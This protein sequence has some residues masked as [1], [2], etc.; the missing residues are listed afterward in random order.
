MPIRSNRYFEEFLKTNPNAGN[1]VPVTDEDPASM[2]FLARDIMEWRSLSLVGGYPGT[3]SYEPNN[4]LLL[5]SIGHL[6]FF[7]GVIKNWDS[8]NY[9]N[10]ILLCRGKEGIVYTISTTS[11]LYNYKDSQKGKEEYRKGALDTRKTFQDIV[12]YLSYSKDRTVQEMQ[13]IHNYHKQP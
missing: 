9:W 1:Y 12:P 10:D 5:I 8:Y 3:F 2:R 4:R 6:K 13:K 11:I 7:P